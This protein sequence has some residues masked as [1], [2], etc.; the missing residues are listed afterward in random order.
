LVGAELFWGLFTNNQ[1]KINDELPPLQ[2]TVHGWVIK[3]ASP[4]TQTPTFSGFIVPT[5]TENYLSL[6]FRKINDFVHRFIL[7]HKSVDFTILIVN[8]TI[9]YCKLYGFT[10]DFTILLLKSTIS[11]GKINSETIKSTNVRSKINLCTK[12]LIIRK[13]ILS[14]H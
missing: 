4:T 1:L 12:S 14:E 11:N 2:E 8:F 6:I 7:D 10:V 13:K 5:S 9:L 3:I